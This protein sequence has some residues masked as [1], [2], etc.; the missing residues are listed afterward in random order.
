[1]HYAT[2]L[3]TCL[4]TKPKVKCSDRLMELTFITPQLQVHRTGTNQAKGVKM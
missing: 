3:S 1:M 4:L 2:L